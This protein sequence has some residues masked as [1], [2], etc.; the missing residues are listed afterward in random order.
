M[1]L[2]RDK[3]IYL[4]ES[5]SVKFVWALEAIQAKFELG[6]KQTEALCSIIPRHDPKPKPAMSVSKPVVQ[7]L[8]LPLLSFM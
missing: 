2:D 6:K 1:V 3:A 4:D 8:P 7:Y 5:V